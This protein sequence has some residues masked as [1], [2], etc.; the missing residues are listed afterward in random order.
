MDIFLSFETFRNQLPQILAKKNKREHSCFDFIE[1]YLKNEKTYIP[2]EKGQANI[3]RLEKLY[4]KL[5]ELGKIEEKK[6]PKSFVP[7]DVPDE[8]PT[9]SDDERNCATIG[10]LIEYGTFHGMR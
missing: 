5:Q 10:G 4:E 8:K 1:V 9:R 3:E 7:V 2:S 6:D